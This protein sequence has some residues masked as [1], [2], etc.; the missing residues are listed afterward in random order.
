MGRHAYAQDLCG[1]PASLTLILPLNMWLEASSHC[2][3][4][5]SK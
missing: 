4:E 3:Q 1:I 5:N 2:H